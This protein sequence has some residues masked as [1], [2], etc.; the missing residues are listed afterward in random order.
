MDIEPVRTG[1]LGYGHYI[2]TNFA[3]H[4]KRC[5]SL[6]ILGVY[7]RGEE[8]RKQA[9]DDGYFATSNLDELL[10]LPGLEAVVIGTA[11][12]AHREQAVKAADAGKHILCEKPIALCLEDAE[13]MTEAAERNGVITHV[14]H[15]SVYSPRYAKLKDVIEEYAGDILHMY[16]RGSRTFG[17]WVQG[18]R[19]GAVADPEKS[20]GWTFHHMCHQL[21][22]VCVILGTDITQVY[23]I[24]QKSCEEAPSEEIVNS[25][26]HFRNGATAHITDTT[27]LGAFEDIIVQG[28]EAD[29]RL[30][31]DE[32]T[33]TLPG[34]TD[35]GGRPG[36]LG[37][38]VKSFK[39][40][41]EGK[42]HEETG[43]RFA[44]AVR[45]G[46]NELL[47]FAFIKDQYRILAAM[48]KSA[49]SGEAVRL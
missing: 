19:H 43:H 1:I 12:V 36:N 26:L 30:C 11:N 41:G 39:A 40:E 38:N 18:A 29:I 31:S 32:I 2:R 16:S 45:G 34:P 4:L 44:R 22:E 28:T 23:H 5:S 21:N 42:G 27:S 3:R 14:N 10:N 8:R 47:S 49:E 9:E 24:S 46:K 20:G 48:K 13:E 35:A 15:G 25:F 33:V 7:N 37:R 6:D 17:L